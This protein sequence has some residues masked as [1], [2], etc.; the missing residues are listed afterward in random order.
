MRR[1]SSLVVVLLLLAPAFASAQQ[2]PIVPPGEADC[3][4]PR[5]ALATWLGNLQ[6]D[7]DHP[8]QAARCF[9]WAAVRI[10]DHDRQEDLVRHFKAVLDARGLYVSMDDIPDEEDPEETTTVTPFEGRLP[11]F[12]LIRR[13]DSQW[14]VS[15]DTIRRIPS[16]YDETFAVDI[17]DYLADAPDW[18]LDKV[19]GVAWWQI[20]ALLI[21]LALAFGLRYLV[22]AVVQTY[23]T[24]LL[25][26]AVKSLDAKLLKRAARPI[27]TVIGVLVVMYALPTLRFSVDFNRVVIFG[28]RV[29]AAVS[30]VV[31][32]YRLV[33]VGSDVFAKRADDTE[34]KLDDQLVPL[35]RKSLKVVTVVLGIV[36]VL[37]NMDVEIGSLIA[38]VSLGGLAFT[39]AARDTVANL[40]GSVSIFADQPFQVGDWVVMQGVEGVVEEVGMRST[41]VRTFYK[42]LVSIPNSKVADGVIDNYGM[43][44]LRR[45]YLKL[46]LQYDTTPEQIEAFCE[47]VRAILA[48]N[49]LVW[50]DGYYV[51]FTGFGDSALEVMLYFFFDTNSWDDELVARHNIFLEVL[52]VAK[53]LGV[54]F[55]FPTRTLHLATRAK[56]TEV[57]PAPQP[58]VEDLKAAVLAFGPG[59]AMSRPGGPRITEDGF[60]HSARLRGGDD[61]DAD[62][63]DS[64]E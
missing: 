28:L 11:Q 27:G 13:D 62:V 35:V 47:G 17:E 25:K 56:E 52:R 20:I 38:G 34:T 51:H 63:A 2:E 46:G 36:F 57:P 26:R 42:S 1:W 55:A 37:Q 33:D 44:N 10:H 12:Y 21:L 31:I 43:R 16:W 7:E 19:W 14:V 58:S 23:G 15:A 53:E 5:R 50:K 24:R 54:S 30:G 32:V 3:S 6:D 45:T 60:M 59:G 48:S 18:L 4:T 39:L 40:F 61:P 64:R 9:D 8:R 29:A 41:R 22:S 49:D